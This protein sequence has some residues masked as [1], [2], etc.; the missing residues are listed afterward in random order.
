MLLSM[1]GGLEGVKGMVAEFHKRG[2][3]VLFPFMLWDQGTRDPGA[4]WPGAL[5]R[6]MAEIDADGMNGD[7]QDG[8]PLSFSLAA[9]ATG[10]SLVFQP[11]GP[12]HDEAL[13][14]NLMSWGQ[15]NFDF[16]PKIDRFRWL[17][18]QHMVNISDR[19]NR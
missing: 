1:P 11:E 14:W 2:V 12:P 17:E 19:W 6:L 4:P 15:Y 13:S 10:H 16:V 7:T 9:E 3:R 8:T 5:A 18:P